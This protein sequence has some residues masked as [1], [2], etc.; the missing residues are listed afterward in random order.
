VDTLAAHPYA[1]PETPGDL[2]QN[3]P[4]P[5]ERLVLVTHAVTRYHLPR[6][7]VRQRLADWK[8]ALNTGR[9]QAELAAMTG[10]SRPRVSQLSTQA[11]R[12]CARDQHQ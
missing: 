3:V 4:D 12:E 8:A 6:R 2:V 10:L 5:V 7:W 11:L 1:L 9:T